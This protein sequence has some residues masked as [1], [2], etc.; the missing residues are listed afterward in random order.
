M[1]T[2]TSYLIEKLQDPK[3]ITLGNWNFVTGFLGRYHEPVIISR[4]YQGEV[5]AAAATSLAL[6]YF[7]PKAVINQGIGGGHDKRFHRGD[8][9][10]GEKVIPMGA[11]QT[12]FAKEG[13]GIDARAWKPQPLEVFCRK[14]QTTEKVF[15][16]PCEE[17]LIAL[18]ESV[19]SSH[20]VGRGVIG[21]ADEWN[22][23]LDRIALFRERYH[24]AVEDMESAAPAQLC[25]S[26][27]IPFIGIR[28]LS[29]S[30]VNDEEFDESV[31]EICQQF[32]LSYVE[33]L[34][35]YKGRWE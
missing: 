18:A 13:E 7:V 24:T 23:E 8:I 30:I 10:L 29:N 14:K 21:S 31:G 4:T 1:E 26:Y 25:Y 27:D 5:N 9:V 22:N 15:D 16:F 34:H 35:N 28:I 3:T 17:E 11:F 19:V 12:P 2:E 33:V 6:F 20:N 32:I